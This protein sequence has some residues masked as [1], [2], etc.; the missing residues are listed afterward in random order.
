MMFVDS[1]KIWLF[2]WK[3]C[4]LIWICHHEY[5]SFSELEDFLDEM[6][7]DINEYGV[8]GIVY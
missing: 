6:R 2:K 1:D 4:W 3:L 5:D 8:F 7:G